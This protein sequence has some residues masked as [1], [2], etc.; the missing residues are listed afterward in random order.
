MWE[1]VPKDSQGV[2]AGDPVSLGGLH[3]QIRVVGFSFKGH[4]GPISSLALQSK[5]WIAWSSFP[6]TEIPEWAPVLCEILRPPG[7]D[8]SW[9]FYAFMVLW[10]DQK[11][12]DERLKTWCECNF[13][14]AFLWTRE[15]ISSFNK[16]FEQHWTC[17]LRDSKLW[18]KNTEPVVKTVAWVAYSKWKV[19]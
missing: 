14:A 5:I 11:V 18:T 2:F 15:V 17:S 12:T 13:A 1:S 10:L 16:I 19:Y 6:N 7:S 9:A 8:P 3:N 4:W